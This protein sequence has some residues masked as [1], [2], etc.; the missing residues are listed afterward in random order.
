LHLTL[1]TQRNP[2]NIDEHKSWLQSSHPHSY[3]FHHN[4]MKFVILRLNT[5][6]KPSPI[7]EGVT[8]IIINSQPC[9]GINLTTKHPW[10][11]RA[12]WVA[13]AHDVVNES[14]RV[15][16]RTSVAF[17]AYAS[18]NT[19][20]VARTLS[21]CTPVKWDKVL[22]NSVTHEATKFAGP[23]KS[24]MHQYII[25]CLH[26]R[27]QPTC[28]LIDTGE[29]YHLG[30]PNLWSRPLSAFPSSILHFPLIAP[31]GLQLC[32]HSIILLNPHRTS[33]DRNGP[34]VRRFQPP[35]SYQ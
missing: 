26:F 2:S 10:A 11:R 24:H 34:I 8:E 7:S 13:T 23:H 5:E 15:L 17:H 1:S 35:V 9:N 19:P 18:A 28:G 33:I 12:P 30:A 27:D 21:H 29:G 14:G 25:K 20:W 4:N 31:P 6:V 32:Q 3:S 22:S 16:P